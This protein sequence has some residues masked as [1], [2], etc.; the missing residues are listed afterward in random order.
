MAIGE[1][2]TASASLGSSQSLTVVTGPTVTKPAEEAKA[3][4]AATQKAL[5]ERTSELTAVREK[6]QGQVRAHSTTLSRP[7]STPRRPLFF[8]LRVGFRLQAW[9]RGLYVPAPPYLHAVSTLQSKH[10]LYRLR[11]DTPNSGSVCS[12]YGGGLH[13]LFHSPTDSLLV[14]HRIHTMY[15]L[16]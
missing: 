3:E 14:L 9:T 12:G 7:H 5:A 10:C 6:F 1:K 13:R 8:I 15:L 16:V 11:C 2:P 4:L